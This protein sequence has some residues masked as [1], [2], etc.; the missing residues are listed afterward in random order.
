MGAL[1]YFTKIIE[2]EFP[3]FSVE[4]CF[5]KLCKLHDKIEQHGFIDSIEHRF[6]I[7]AYKC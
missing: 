6:L 5:D 7:V 2:W 4:K 3:G 1:V